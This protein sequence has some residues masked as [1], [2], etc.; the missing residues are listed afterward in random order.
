MATLKALNKYVTDHLSIKIQMIIQLQDYEIAFL[1]KHRALHKLT[2]ME[3]PA[4][5]SQNFNQSAV[6]ILP[7]HKTNSIK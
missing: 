6:K 3:K 5:S 4:L 2:L 1:E 7:I